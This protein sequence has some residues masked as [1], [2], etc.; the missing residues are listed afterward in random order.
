M[1]KDMTPVKLL[2]P[3]YYFFTNLVGKEAIHHNTYHG[4]WILHAAETY[5][6]A[7]GK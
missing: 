5:L 6:V 1:L 4:T 3:S 7:A 2:F